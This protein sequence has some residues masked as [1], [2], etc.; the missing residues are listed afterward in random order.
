MPPA[1]AILGSARSD[2]H[3]AALLAR[4]IEGL[5]CEVFDLNQRR[6]AAFRYDQKYADDGDEFSAVIEK[7]LDAPVTIFATPVYW[8]SCSWLMKAFIDRLSDLL[9]SRKELGRRLRGRSFA[10]LTSGS[11]AEPDA[12]VVSAFKRL[13]EY[14]GVTYIGL[15][16][17]AEAGPFVDAQSA[18]RVRGLIGSA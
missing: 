11:D 4:L 9:M 7:M 12:D 18:E 2:G 15:V 5:N 10:L 1:L 13:C 6:V 17:G 14:L 8:Y 16:H 3:T